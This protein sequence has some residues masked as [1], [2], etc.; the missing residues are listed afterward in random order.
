[1]KRNVMFA[2]FLWMIAFKN[3]LAA[4]RALSAIS[5]RPRESRCFAYFVITGILTAS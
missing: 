4:D 3:P 1:M 5:L 2:V